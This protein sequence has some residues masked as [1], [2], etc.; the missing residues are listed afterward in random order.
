[1]IFVT[2]SATITS[3]AI[4]R[5]LGWHPTNIYVNNVSSADVWMTTATRVSSADTVNGS[6]STGYL[7]DVAAP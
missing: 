2:T 1:M 7:K 4:L 5:S 3:Y 6:V